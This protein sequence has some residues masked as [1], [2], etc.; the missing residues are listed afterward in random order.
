MRFPPFVPPGIYPPF[1]PA[2][3]F[4][5]NNHD[6]HQSQLQYG[7]GQPATQFYY[8]YQIQVQQETSDSVAVSASGATT[9]PEKSTP[10]V[11]K[12]GVTKTG[13]VKK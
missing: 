8:D 2:P 9:V 3:P 10:Q 13:D 12:E 6:Y 11:A 1:P 7:S 5:W 4:A